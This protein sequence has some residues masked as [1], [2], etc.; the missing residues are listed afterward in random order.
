MIGEQDFIKTWTDMETNLR[1]TIERNEAEIKKCQLSV[2][3]N[4]YSKG[5][6]TKP[7]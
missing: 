6:K 7:I 5:A 3:E 2:S 1:D 4:V